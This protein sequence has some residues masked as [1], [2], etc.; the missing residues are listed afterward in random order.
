MAG[1][2]SGKTALVLDVGGPVGHAVCRRFAEEGARVIGLYFR[3]ASDAST[4]TDTTAGPA[5]VETVLEVDV[6]DSETIESALDTALHPDT[7]VDIV[8]NPFVRHGFAPIETVDHE[9]WLREIEWNLGIT[10]RLIRAVSKQMKERRSGSIVTVSSTAKDG[11]P[12]FS[13]SGHATHAAARGG[14]LGLTRSLAYELGRY[15]VRVN[16]VVPG[17]VKASDSATPFDAL[18]EDPDAAV[19]PEQTF[20][21]RRYG[22]PEDVANAILFFASDESAY[23]TGQALYVSGGFYY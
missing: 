18:R 20:A 2:L 3:E 13:H 14:I 17:P 10:F 16:C 21:L 9:T 22:T 19:L 7:L 23:V 15:S 4:S 6:L 12:W 8:C 11:V 5:F 1:R